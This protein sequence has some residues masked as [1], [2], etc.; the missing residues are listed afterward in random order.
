MYCKYIYH[1]RLQEFLLS[2]S[3]MRAEEHGEHG[4]RSQLRRYKT[5]DELIR[6]IIDSDISGK[7]LQI[8]LQIIRQW[9]EEQPGH[10]SE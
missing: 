5:M 8:V 10:A 2:T 1:I 9:E 6:R 4:N 3:G 7:D